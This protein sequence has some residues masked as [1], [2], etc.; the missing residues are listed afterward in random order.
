V[1]TKCLL[2]RVVVPVD[3]G[4]RILRDRQVPPVT[5]QQ[6]RS[7]LG[8]V[9]G[10]RRAGQRGPVLRGVGDAGAQPG[11]REPPGSSR[12]AVSAVPLRTS[13]R[14]WTMSGRPVGYSVFRQERRR[15]YPVR[16]SWF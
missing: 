16:V 14:L 7:H 4:F 8:R 2:D 1:T 3:R 10:L 13:A 15:E 11:V 9:A 6:E 12:P 5:R